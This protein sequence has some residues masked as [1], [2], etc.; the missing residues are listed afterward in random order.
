MPSCRTRWRRSPPCCRISASQKGDRVILYMP[1][2]PEAVFAML[3]CAR[4]GAIHSVVF[5]GFAAKELATRIDDAK[6]KVI[7]SASC[8]IEAARVVPYKPLL[9]EAIALCHHKPE[10]CLVFQRPQFA[11]ALI[12]GRDHDWASAVDAARAARAQGRCV[13]V[14]ATDPLYI[15]YTSGTTG[16]PKGVVR[17]NGGHMVALKWSMGNLYGVEPGEVLL[18]RLRRRLGGR[19]FLHRLR[20]AAAWLHD[21]A[22]RGQAGG[23]AR[24]RRLL[25]GDR[26]ARGRDAVHRAH[27]LPRH[28]EGGPERRSSCKTYDLSALPR[29]VPRRRAR[30]SRHGAMGRATSCRCRSSTIGGRR[31]PAG[32]SPATRSA[33]ERCR[34]ST[35]RRRCRCR[36]TTCRC[37]TKAA[38]RCA[39]DTMGTIAIKLPLPPGCL[40][41]LWQADERFREAYLARLSRLLQHLGCGLHRRGRL[42]LRHGPHRRHHQ[43]RRP[44]ALDRRHGGGAGLPSGRRRMRRHRRE[45]FA[46]GRGARAASSC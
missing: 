6:P 45:G 43:R 23:H 34:S 3:A 9:D 18:G 37:S 32:R 30:R 14:A 26:R 8:G 24:C 28:Q 31:K 21:G 5:G 36:A 15:L 38:S 22:L 10:A 39:P 7:L 33:S 42:R 16:E 11:C 19:P 41:T 12:D 1:M 27:R 25:A 4:I 13:P 2:I 17:D 29:P 46:E 40:P 20:A 44:P 35:A